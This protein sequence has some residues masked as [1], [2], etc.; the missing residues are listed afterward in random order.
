MQIIE[1]L[2][3]LV[4]DR[5][6]ATQGVNW[7]WIHQRLASI[8]PEEHILHAQDCYHGEGNRGSLVATTDEI[9]WLT[10]GMFHK[11]DVPI[12]YGWKVE[13]TKYGGVIGTATALM[14]GAS[15]GTATRNGILSIGGEQFQ[16]KP[17]ECDYFAQLIRQYQRL[18]SNL[19]S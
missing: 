12:G 16:M 2:A 9:W 18:L 10:N 13:T 3:P 6:K 8:A 5:I 19:P 1:S 7:G 4:A 17:D 15:L 11:E 14:G